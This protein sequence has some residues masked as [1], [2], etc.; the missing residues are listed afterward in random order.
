[1]PE[2]SEICDDGLVIDLSRIKYVHV[3]PA[4]RDCARRRRS[5]LGRC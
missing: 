5:Y 2:D 1:M 4:A 3:D